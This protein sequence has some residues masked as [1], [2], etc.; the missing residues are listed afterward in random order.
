MRDEEIN[1]LGSAAN[2]S[3]VTTCVSAVPC[4]QEAVSFPAVQ[5]AAAVQGTRPLTGFLC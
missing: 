3:V 5:E 1:V 2:L 4:T